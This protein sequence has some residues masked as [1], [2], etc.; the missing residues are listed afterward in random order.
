MLATTLPFVLALIAL[1]FLALVLSMRA[2]FLTGVPVHAACPETISA[3]LD[4]LAL[5]DGERFFD[6]GCGMGAVLR[7]ARRRADVRAIGVELNPPV[8]LLTGLRSLFDRKI[9]VRVRDLRKMPMDDIDAAYF[10]LMPYSLTQVGPIFEQRM[11][12]G[13]RLVAI[14]FPVPDWIPLETR[15]AG[16]LRQPVRLY[17]LGKHRAPATG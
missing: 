17:V 9:R 5:K 4:L 14:D 11:R 10:Y 1:V 3:A 16:P 7:E 13:T 8:A 2:L 6:L 15:E 12:P